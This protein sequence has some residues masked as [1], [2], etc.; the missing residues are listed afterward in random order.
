MDTPSTV[1]EL[2]DA[3]GGPT[4][5][6]KVIDKNPSTASEMKR[7]GS[8]RVNYWPAIVAAATRQ[9]NPIPGV[10]LESIARMHIVS[11]QR[12]AA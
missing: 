1:P 3:F 5:F 9:R 10:S 2:I 4:E 12:G 11:Q 6:A 7:S 8:I